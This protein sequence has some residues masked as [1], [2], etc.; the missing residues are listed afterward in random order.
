MS[1]SVEA[2]A[3]F[4]LFV[5]LIPLFCSIWQYIKRDHLT[6]KLRRCK[7]CKSCKPPFG[8]NTRLFFYHSRIEGILSGVSD[9]NR[10]QPGSML[11]RH[12]IFSHISAVLPQRCL[13]RSSPTSVRRITSKAQDQRTRSIL[14]DY[15]NIDA[16]LSDKFSKKRGFP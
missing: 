1:I 7:P 16:F 4:A 2:I 14:D 3:I 8:S 15:K 10:S 5:A 9:L 12:P 13:P 6:W 11:L